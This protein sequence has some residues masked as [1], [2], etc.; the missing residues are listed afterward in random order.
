MGGGSSEVREL[1]EWL[2]GIEKELRAQGVAIRGLQ[3]RM[4]TLEKLYNTGA[5]PEE[6]KPRKARKR[7]VKAGG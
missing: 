4:A 5:A 2:E 3:K 1:R 6:A 7:R